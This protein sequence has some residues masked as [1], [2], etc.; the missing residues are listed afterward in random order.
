M[1]HLVV[2]VEK[3]DYV[4]KKTGEPRSFIKLGCVAKSLKTSSGKQV[5]EVM[6]FDS[7]TNVYSGLLRDFSRDNFENLNNRLINI[8]YD[9]NKQICE[10]E[11][12]PP[13]PDSVIWGF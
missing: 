9:S 5:C 4:D 2:G 7:L 11:V 10:F 8:E 13:D 6:L 12:L 3:V 1:K